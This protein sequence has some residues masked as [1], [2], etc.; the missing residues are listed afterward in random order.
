MK[1]RKKPRP[2][3]ST[4]SSRA[5]TQTLL[6]ELFRAENRLRYVMGLA[7]TDGRLI[8]PID[9]PTV[10]KVDFDW[11]EITEEALAP[12]PRPAAAEVAHQAARAGIDRR[13]EL[14]V[15]AIGLERH[16]PLAG[17]GRQRSLTA[18]ESARFDR[19]TIQHGA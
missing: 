13:Q 1:P 12:Q 17:P 4:F 8:R 6:N 19:P 16:V 14:A 5:T 9:K 10:A 18:V 7:A 2:A 11:H 3:S 15:A